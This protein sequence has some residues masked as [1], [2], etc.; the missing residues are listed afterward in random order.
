MTSRIEKKPDEELPVPL[1]WRSMLKYIADE[2]VA[3]RGPV[4]DNIK[5][6]DAKSLE[7]SLDNIRAYPDPIGSLQDI[8][9]QSSIYVW[10]QSCWEVLVDLSTLGNETSDLILHLRVYEL[11]NRYV[12]EPGLIYVP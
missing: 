1:E 10:A 12:F 4:A 9:W 2:I 5:A 11:N 7:V 3:G 6:V 8:T